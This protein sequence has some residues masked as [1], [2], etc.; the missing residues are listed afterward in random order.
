MF[1]EAVEGI[2][3]TGARPLNVIL[4]GAIPQVVPLWV[5]YTP[6]RFES[7]VRAASV[8]GVLGAGGIG[9]GLGGVVRGLEYGQTAFVL[10]LLVVSVTLIDMA[11]A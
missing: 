10:I 11:W 5:S 9:M 2:R 3:A 4:Y 6:Y 8:V 7:N 1:S